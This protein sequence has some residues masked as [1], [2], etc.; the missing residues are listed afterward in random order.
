MH[1]IVIIGGGAAGA[2]VFG[3]LLHGERANTVHW[4]T[5]GRALGRGVAYATQD[6]RHLLNVRAAGMGLFAG[7]PGDF[8][9]HAMRRR[10]EVSGADFLPRHLF[11]DFIEAQVRARMQR[12]RSQGRHVQIHAAEAVRI[13]CRKDASYA[14]HLASGQCIEARAVVL[15][16]GALSPRA[17]RCVTR[18]ALA[19]GRYV[20]DPWTRLE[21]AP[22]PDR[23]LV[24]GTGLTAVDT[25][26]T[27]SRRWPQAELVAVS[28]HGRLPFPHSVQPLAPFAFQEDLNAQLL[29]SD[30]PLAMLRVFRRTLREAP[31]ADWRS[32]VDG[33]RSVN[34]R[35][36]QSLTV[37]QQRRFLHHMRWLWEAARHRMA[38]A[39]A[40]AIGQLVD[41]G[42]LQVH[43]ARVLAVDGHDRLQVRLRHRK[44]QV[45]DTQYADRVVQATGLDT[46]VAFTRHPLMMQLIEDGLVRPDALQLGL[47]ATPD[48]A[49]I[50]A[51]GRLQRGLY[52]IGSLLRGS[53]WECTA[54]PEIRVAAQG[55][56]RR[57][58]TPPEPD[59]AG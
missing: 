50:D 46:T 51:Q 5:G 35:L 11:G 54:M 13:A 32:I 3:E 59:A 25:L 38:P 39:S 7:Q 29:A 17:L 18:E 33:M 12:A 21:H 49:L 41:E 6:E 20:L 19:S 55:L 10:A 48:G 9:Q 28:R 8:L 24:I 16:V 44:T 36:W 45:L 27:A 14:V 1:N 4:V 53:L 30:G 15:A 34:A 57:I 31:G 26:L 37:R 2:A 58:A 42:R 22:A 23:L 47:V 40:D 43:A 56:A 52:A